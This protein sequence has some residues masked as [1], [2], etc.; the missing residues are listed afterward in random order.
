MNRSDS[1]RPTG[2][3]PPAVPDGRTRMLFVSLDDMGWSTMASAMAAATD[4]RSD[5]DAVH[6]RYRG[7][8]LK[9]L[10]SAPIP[11]GRGR[12]DPHVRR[13]MV[14]R[15]VISR[16][17][18]GPLDLE[19][20]DV[21]HASSQQ[22]GLAFARLPRAGRPILS[23]AADA[24][25]FQAKGTLTG[26][27]DQAVRHQFA[28]LIEVEQAVFSA[29]S[30]VVTRTAWAKADVV[31]R[32]GVDQ[33]QILVSPFTVSPPAN[34]PLP[35]AQPTNETARIAFVGAD[36]ER[37][38]AGRLLRWHQERWADRAELHLCTAQKPPRDC[39]NV[40]CHGLMS[41][42]RVLDLLATMDLFVL[43][44]RKD[45]APLAVLEA[46]SLGL[47]VVSS[48]IGGLGETVIDGETGFLRSPDD[49]RG[50]VEAIERLL[51]DRALRVAMGK[52]GR[53]RSEQMPSLDPVLDRMIALC[54]TRGGAGSASA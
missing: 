51:D 53:E 41:H 45:M 39:R 26:L 11:G 5:I 36:W 24:T 1:S 31:A 25:V 13:V 49:D 28:P 4:R 35:L 12:L 50:F 46:S 16:W 22:L 52:A 38:G 29:A 40:V 27:G 18:S 20:F 10:L 42:D 47:P 30:L 43:P 9:R 34:G 54:A 6:L 32:F 21:V 48:E 33:D 23:V 7:K 19:R 17:I 14:A 37:K 44:T 2:D 8:G 15:W 3:L